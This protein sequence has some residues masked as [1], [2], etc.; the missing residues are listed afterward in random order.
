M[1]YTLENLHNDRLNYDNIIHGIDPNLRLNTDK[2]KFIYLANYLMSNGHLNT[3]DKEIVESEF[4]KTMMKHS[5]DYPHFK[6]LLRI[7][8]IVSNFS[9]S[10][11]ILDEVE[12]RVM[13]LDDFNRH[14]VMDIIEINNIDL[15][16]TVVELERHGYSGMDLL[17]RLFKLKY[18]TIEAEKYTSMIDDPI[19][20]SLVYNLFFTII[21]FFSNAYLYALLMDNVSDIIQE[22]DTN[23]L[24]Y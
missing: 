20:K 3:D 21:N 10:R 4:F 22:V 8:K 19:N 18:N 13:T 11:E 2:E 17:R 15:L 5:F 12:K 1:A 16:V 14:K 24:E 6:Q 9:N 7:E 23:H